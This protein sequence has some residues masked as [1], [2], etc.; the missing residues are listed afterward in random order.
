MVSQKRTQRISERIFEELSTILVMEAADPRLENVTIT[1]V[2]V[3]KELSFADIYISSLSGSGNSVEILEG[4]NHAK[5][6]LRSELARR[7]EVRYMPQLR[8]H[9]DPIPE[10][11]DRIDRLIASLHE[12]ENPSAFE[13]DQELQDE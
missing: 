1:Y 10:K 7:V 9:W 2:R 11:V 3:D 4:L 13:E 6:Y 8:F 5:G 12:D